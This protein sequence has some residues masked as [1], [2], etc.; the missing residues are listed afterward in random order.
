MRTTE[1]QPEAEAGM[2]KEEM[3]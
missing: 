1:Q 3:K 2:E